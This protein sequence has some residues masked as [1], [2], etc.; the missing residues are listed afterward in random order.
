MVK[1][2][3]NLEKTAMKNKIILALT[4]FF[5]FFV[6]FII[7][8]ANQ[9]DDLIFF[10]IL[11]QIPMGDKIG[12]TILVGSL[13]LLLNWSLQMRTFLVG[14]WLLLMGSCIVFGLTT[15]EEFSQ[16]WITNRTFDLVDLA[17]NYL[18]ILIASLWM[19]YKE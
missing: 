16:I 5:I 1:S 3:I 13:T 15:I 17:C 14:R 7:Y 11:K 6:S 10:K 4:L 2:A 9:G 8:S 12:H 19:V 18:G